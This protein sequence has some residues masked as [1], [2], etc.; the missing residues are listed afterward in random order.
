M[1]FRIDGTPIPD[2]AEFTA[3]ISDLDTLGTRDLTGE[4]HRN[5]V[6]TKHHIEF[7]YRNIEWEMV[8]RICATMNGKEFFDVTYIDPFDGEI[9]VTAYVG[10]RTLESVMNPADGPWI[11]SVSFNIIEK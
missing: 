7:R 3:K 2:P 8:M 4:L 10:D 1:G 9:T 11:G 5:M 6:A